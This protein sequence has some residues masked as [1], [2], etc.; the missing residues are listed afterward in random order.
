MLDLSYENITC[1]AMGLWG[2]EDIYMDAVD[3]YR[4]K[5]DM[6]NAQVRLQMI[7][8]AGHLAMVDQPHM[9]ADAIID[10]ISEYRGVDALAK[11]YDGFP[12]VL[13]AQHVT[14]E[15]KGFWG[16]GE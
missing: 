7:R 9:V 12:E 6:K 8:E 4:F 5:R 2:T 16:P 13:G 11:S 10:F 14:D 3:L 15:F 1:P